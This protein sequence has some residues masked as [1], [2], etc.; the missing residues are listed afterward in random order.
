MDWIMQASHASMLGVLIGSF[1][2][3]LTN[4]FRM[5]S[6]MNGFDA[7]SV[8]QVGVV[9]VEGMVPVVVSLA[10]LTVAWACAAIGMRRGS[11]S[12]GS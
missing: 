7:G 8:R 2:L 9:M 4:G 1:V 10:L 11:R 5:V 3:S 12:G 6:R